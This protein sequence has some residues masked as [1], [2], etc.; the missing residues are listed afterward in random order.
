[1]PACGI[2]LRILMDN[3]DA[4]SY[5]RE[6]KG[7]IIKIG[8]ALA[9]RSIPLKSAYFACKYALTGFTDSPRCELLNGKSK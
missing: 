1:V 7:T 2:R 3:G 9:N 5:A 8:S 6:N 4:A